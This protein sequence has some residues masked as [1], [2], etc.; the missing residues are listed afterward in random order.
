MRGA[1]KLL[2]S[3]HKAAH[4]PMTPADQV[5]PFAGRL[6]KLLCIRKVLTAEEAANLLVDAGQDVGRARTRAS[7]LLLAWSRQCPLAIQPSDRRIKGAK[8]YGLMV[9]L[10]PTPPDIRAKA[11]SRAP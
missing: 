11:R 10:G 4:G 8:R 3:L 2:P 5:E 6:W 9:D 1:K 7:E